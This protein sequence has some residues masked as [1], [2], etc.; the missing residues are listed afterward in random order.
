MYL[1]AAV[2][3]GAEPVFVPAG[4]DNGF[5][6]DFSALPEETLNRTVLAYYCSPANPQGAI[7]SMGTM[8]TL[9]GLAREHDFLLVSDEC[10]SELYY[11]DPPTGA[12]EACAAQRFAAERRHHELT[13][14]TLQRTG[15]TIGSSP[16]IDDPP[17]RRAARL[18]RG[19]T[20]AA[21]A[22]G[23]RRPLVGRRTRHRQPG[24]IREKYKIAADVL[25]GNFATS[26]AVVFYGSTSATAK[27]PRCAAR[28]WRTRYPRRI[29]CPRSRIS[30]GA[31]YIRLALVHDKTPRPRH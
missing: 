21:A 26:P 29:P 5:L 15:T 13:V 22:G 11:G 6:P 10:Y 23:G 28:C 30:P 31:G 25:G 1:G 17:V 8:K 16:A 18:R 2:M 4:K 3:A 20:A 14:E 19:A 7:A 24:N 27:M 9:I 12:A